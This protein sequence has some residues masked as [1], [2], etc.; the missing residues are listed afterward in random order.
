MPLTEI[1]DVGTR[2]YVY[3]EGEICN[4]LWNDGPADNHFFSD[5]RCYASFPDAVK[6]A[7]DVCFPPIELKSEDLLAACMIELLTVEQI[8][9][10]VDVV[11]EGSYNEGLPFS[12]WL[13]LRTYLNEVGE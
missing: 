13:G 9:Y 11:G 12:T 7:Y 3:L 8:K 2:Y 4:Y 1:P 10:L 5:K 6:A